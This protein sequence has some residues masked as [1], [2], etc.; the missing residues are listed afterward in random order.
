MEGNAFGSRGF[1]FELEHEYQL[2]DARNRGENFLAIDEV[3]ARHTLVSMLGEDCI[4]K[5]GWPKPHHKGLGA[6]RRGEKKLKRRPPHPPGKTGRSKERKEDVV[7][8]RGSSEAGGG[9]LS[10]LSGPSGQ[11]TV[12]LLSADLPKHGRWASKRGSAGQTPRR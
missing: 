3:C 6:A 12:T 4:L 5:K 7:G 9:R 10:R 11:L 1:R 2:I 8:G